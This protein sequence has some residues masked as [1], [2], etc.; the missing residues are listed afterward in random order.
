MSIMIPSCNA[1]AYM[2]FS[3]KNFAPYAKIATVK[4]I[5][6]R[7]K[8][9]VGMNSLDRT[10]IVSDTLQDRNVSNFYF[11]GSGSG[12]GSGFRIPAF[13]YAHLGPASFII[14]ASRQWYLS[15]D[16]FLVFRE[17]NSTSDRAWETVIEPLEKIGS[18]L[19]YAWGVASHLN[20]VRNSPELR[21]SY[22]KVSILFSIDLYTTMT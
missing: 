5:I 12:S 8:Y 15:Y 9:N 22:E 11:L 3:K 20:G 1:H 4:N 10:I 19:S 2:K 13:P 6:T 17:N 16:M 7:N 18:Q 14:K 21:N